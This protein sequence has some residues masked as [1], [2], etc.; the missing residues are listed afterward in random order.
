M[1]L[2]VFFFNFRV[3]IQIISYG[4]CLSLSDL[5]FSMIISR[6]IHVA[7]NG[8]ISF[9]MTEYS[10]VYVYHIFFIHCSVDGHLDCFHV[11]ALVNYASMNIGVHVSL[12]G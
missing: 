7:A 4:I 12:L 3:H 10:V 8:Y 2:C 11:L 6:F 5:T 9:F 1:C